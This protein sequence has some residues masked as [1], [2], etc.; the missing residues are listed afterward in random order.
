MK[1][2]G[3]VEDAFCPECNKLRTCQV[4]SVSTEGTRGAQYVSYLCS[5]E[6]R[7]QA[8][9]GNPIAPMRKRRRK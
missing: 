8:R 3:M 5:S 9:V 7:F 1:R 2:N 6:H 4:L